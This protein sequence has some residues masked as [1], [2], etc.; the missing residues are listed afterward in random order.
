LAKDK[1][2][3]DVKRLQLDLPP[4]SIE[5]LEKLKEITEASSY[6][7]VVKQ[8]FRLYEWFIHQREMGYEVQLT[9]DGQT[10]SIGPIFSP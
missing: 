10:V 4:A 3:R 7:E 6:A 5:R 2:N 9:K 8:S 1:S